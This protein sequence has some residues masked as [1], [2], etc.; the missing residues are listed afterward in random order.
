MVSKFSERLKDLRL[1][2]ELS[3]VKL[4]KETGISQNAFVHWEKERRVPNANAVIT[5]AMYFGVTADYILGLTND[6]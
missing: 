4:A 2:K 3:Y 1:E 5:L 6:C